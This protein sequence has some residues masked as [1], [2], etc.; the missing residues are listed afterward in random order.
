M[1]LN[2]LLPILQAFSEGKEVEYKS[3][4]L[5]IPWSVITNKDFNGWFNND[6]TFRIKKEVRIFRIRYC[7]Q[8]SAHDCIRFRAN[9]PLYEVCAH[10]SIIHVQELL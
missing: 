2:E 8:N 7:D 1:T 5:G 6:C 10:C 9:E 4:K 3:D